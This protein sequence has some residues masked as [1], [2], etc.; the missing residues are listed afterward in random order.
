MVMAQ[1]QGIFF[2]KVNDSPRGNF[3]K[4]GVGK[5]R[6]GKGPLYVTFDVEEPW[7][8]TELHLAVADSLDKIPQKN[9]NPIPGKFPDKYKPAAPGACEHTHTFEV[10]FS[11]VCNDGNPVIAAH[12][13][14]KDTTG[15]PCL[16]PVTKEP[17]GETCYR[18]ETAWGKGDDFS[19]ANWAMYFSASN[20]CPQTNGE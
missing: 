3:R 16:D 7:C 5:A 19:G 1:K 14:V 17:T 9:G 18:T 6:N 13:K 12:A 11:L 15:Y 2:R 4:K 10:P 20:C 8:F